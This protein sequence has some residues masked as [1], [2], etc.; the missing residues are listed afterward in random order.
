MELYREKK[1]QDSQDIAL[2]H[3]PQRNEEN[4]VMLTV[5]YVSTQL[6]ILN[7]K[8][9]LDLP[10]TTTEGMLCRMTDIKK[11]KQ[12]KQKTTV[13]KHPNS[14]IYKRMVVCGNNS[15]CFNSY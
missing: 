12:N 9:I 10:D 15:K 8:L 5:N 7:L 2:G 14:H 13:C 1:S 3:S 11:L 4:I 6:M